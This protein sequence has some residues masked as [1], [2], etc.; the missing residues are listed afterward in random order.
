MIPIS[1]QNMPFLPSISVTKNLTMN[2]VFMGESNKMIVNALFNIET[3]SRHFN[4]RIDLSSLYLKAASYDL[5]AGI[6]LRTGVKP[7]PSHELSQLRSLRDATGQ[8]KDAIESTLDCLGLERASK[9]S[10]A[11]SYRALKEIVK[12]RADK[13]IMFSKIDYLEEN[14]L[15]SDCYY[16]IGKIGLTHLESNA[17]NMGEIYPKLVNLTFD[18]N[19][20]TEF[21][22]K[23]STKLVTS[24]KNVLKIKL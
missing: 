14:G 5:I 16:Y 24:C 18:L 6:L 23:M 1:Y 20:D 3:A 9:S 12:N 2:G 17:R 8:I 13:N 22:K 21:L 11:R 4:L 19:L 15:L 10:I 7:M